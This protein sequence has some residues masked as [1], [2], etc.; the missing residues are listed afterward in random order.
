MNDDLSPL[1]PVQR[2]WREVVENYSRHLETHFRS[3]FLL[4]NTLYWPQLPQANNIA[5]DAVNLDSP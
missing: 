4:W 5:E 2:S 1:P 3:R